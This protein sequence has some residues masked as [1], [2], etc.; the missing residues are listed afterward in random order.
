MAGQERRKE[1]QRGGKKQWRLTRARVGAEKQQ[2]QEVH[3]V[4]NRLLRFRFSNSTFSVSLS[5]FFL[6][7]LRLP[8]HSSQG[9]PAVLS[10]SLT[11]AS[12]VKTLEPCHQHHHHHHHRRDSVA[13]V[14]PIC[15][16]L[17]FIY[18]GM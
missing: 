8:S 18:S 11:V 6:E 14:R 13:P 2:N 1:G 16:F 15:M 17:P 4:I 7:Y 3:D 9:V 10:I 5:L 12:K